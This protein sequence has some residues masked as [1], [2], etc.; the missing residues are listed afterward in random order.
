MKLELPERFETQRLALRRLKHEDAEEIFY[1]Y[2]SKPEATRYM[3]WPTHQTIKDTHSFLRY[4][5]AGWDQGIDYSFGIRLRG[6][7]R[8]VGSIGAMNDLGKI[9]FG[10]VFS[11]TQW[12]NGY[13]TEACLA[14]ISLL[15]TTPGVK[16]IGTFV[17]VENKASRRVLQ[18]AGLTE[19]FIF[20]KW[21]AFV[22]QSNAL[23][24]C[25]LFSLPEKH[26]L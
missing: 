4:A 25:V 21:F 13:A 3:A 16:R 1:T 20:S 5:V 7:N 23:K 15:K 26:T 14:L 18:K 2:A 11:P 22:N 9:Q 10:Y 19:D 12:G 8:F 17:D 6:S 24:D